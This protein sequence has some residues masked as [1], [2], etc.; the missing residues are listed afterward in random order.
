MKPGAHRRAP[1]TTYV[2]PPRADIACKTC[3][4]SFGS[5]AISPG[6]NYRE[7][8]TIA[9]G[10]PPVHPPPNPCNLHAERQAAIVTLKIANGNQAKTSYRSA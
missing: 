10:F 9:N 7:L 5:F 6:K 4:F 3:F 2:K 8:Q 1:G